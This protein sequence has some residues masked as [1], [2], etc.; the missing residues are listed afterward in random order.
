VERVWQDDDRVELEL[1][2]PVERMY[3]HPNV[4]Q[5][6][7][8]VALQRGP[9]V[10]CLEGTDNKAPLHRIVVPGIT[11]LASHFEPD[12]PGAMVVRGKALVEEDTDWTETLYRS[13]PASLQPGAI[14][15]IPYYAWDN[16]QPGEMRVWL[17]EGGS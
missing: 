13:R 6:A 7:G 17:R 16:R 15:A 10:Y 4:R 11:E 12:L 3:A 9:L 14:T 1:A 5:D 2:M 8:C